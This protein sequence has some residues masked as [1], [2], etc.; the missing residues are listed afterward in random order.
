MNAS[1]FWRNSVRLY[2]AAH[3]V[4][5]ALPQIFG[6]RASGIEILVDIVEYVLHA[7]GL[8]LADLG[9]REA[10]EEVAQTIPHGVPA[11]RRLMT[12]RRKLEP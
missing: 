11:F 10:F 12:V 3:F 2:A 5:V 7:L 8:A 9:V 4:I 1:A 6:F